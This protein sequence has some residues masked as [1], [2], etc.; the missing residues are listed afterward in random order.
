MRAAPRSSFRPGRSP[1]GSRAAVRRSFTPGGESRKRSP[2]E[3]ALDRIQEA[4]LRLDRKSS[5]LKKGSVFAVAATIGFGVLQGWPWLLA[6]AIPLALLFWWLDGS[7]TRADER[8]QRLYDAVFEGGMAPPVMG[9]ESGA[10]DGLADPPNA[11]RRSLLSGP[12]SG[13]HLMMVGIAVVCNLLL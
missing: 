10:A 11:L 12:G 8:L 3:A 6:L 2:R 7:L 4:R 9:A 13:L 5:R 1:S